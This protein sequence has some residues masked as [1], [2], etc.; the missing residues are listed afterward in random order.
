MGVVI[1]HVH[2]ST[3]AAESLGLFFLN[4]CVP[5]FF[6]TALTYFV[7]GL[8][9]TV[10]VQ[11]T[12]TKILKRIGIPFLTW[13]FVYTAL[14][15]VKSIVSGK[16]YSLDLVR[17]FLYGESAEHMYY[18]PEL[19]AMQ[20]LALGIYLVAHRTKLLAGLLLIAIPV[21]YLAWGH[22][23]QYFGTTPTKCVIVYLAASF[24]IAPFIKSNTK[25]VSLLLLGIALFIL[26]IVVYGLGITSSKFL[27]DYL[28]SLPLSGIGLLLIA[29]NISAISLPTWTKSITTATYGI[30]LSHVMFLE[31]FEFIFEK[32]HQTINY[33]LVNK[34]A[35]ALLI[36]VACVVF[37]LIVRRISFL[38]PLVLGES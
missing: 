20:L 16:P 1:I 3:A 26:P 36:F 10:D 6:V 19:L 11:R 38:R 13:S 34:L 4:F 37:I 9:P 24:L 31:A 18:L 21:A 29:L 35:V 33:D 8:S 7:N 14:L 30:Y 12:V 32:T 28:F 2:S 17:I 22:W 15:L 27:N 25:H 23:H 5:F